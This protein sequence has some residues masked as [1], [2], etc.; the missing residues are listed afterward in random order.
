LEKCFV[1]GRDGERSLTL[2]K[3]VECFIAQQKVK[4]SQFRS[5]NWGNVPF[6]AE[7]GN[8]PSL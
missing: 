6:A 3:S 5:R 4:K 1:C 2:Q 8:K 7:T